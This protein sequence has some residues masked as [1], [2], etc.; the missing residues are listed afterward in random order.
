MLQTLIGNSLGKLHIPTHLD[1]DVFEAIQQHI[2]TDDAALLN[3]WY[4]LNETTHCISLRTD[5]R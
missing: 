1:E 5:Y 3:D 2:N 4:R